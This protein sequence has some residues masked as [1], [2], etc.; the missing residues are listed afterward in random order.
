MFPEHARLVRVSRTETESK[1]EYSSGASGTCTRHDKHRE[2]PNTAE[3]HFFTCDRKPIFFCLQTEKAPT[4]SS[5]E[6]TAASR[7]RT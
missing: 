3:P 5:R 6:W 1:T 7:A 2:V 4:R